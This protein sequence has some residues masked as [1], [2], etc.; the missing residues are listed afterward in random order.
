MMPCYGQSLFVR[1]ER[2][3]AALQ[4]T[5]TPTRTHTR[6]M[7]PSLLGWASHHKMAV[8]VFTALILVSATA[9]GALLLRQDVAVSTSSQA[10]DV[11]FADG[12]GGV[13]GFGTISVGSSGASATLTLTGVAGAANMQLT[14][15]LQ[16]QNTDASQAY[17]VTL[18]R[19]AAPPAAVDALTFT[20]LDGAS[21][22]KSFDAAAS[23]SATAFT[24]PVS[25][26][27]DI[28]IDMA[29]A[30]GTAAGALGSF[31]LQ[32]QIATV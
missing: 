19:S 28:R 24:L 30:D 14:D 2:I 16:I 8:A 32:F 26:T 1:P 23:A 3:A 29:V 11:Q 10:S 6:T 15:V 27:Y 5:P 9:A 20:V 17:T 31:D 22:I 18:K 13:A 7:P 4:K 25:T 12:G 21:T